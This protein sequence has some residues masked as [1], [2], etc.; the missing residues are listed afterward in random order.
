MSKGEADQEIVEYIKYKD[1]KKQL[2]NIKKIN[3]IDVEI[4]HNFPKFKRIMTIIRSEQ[5]TQNIGAMILEANASINFYSLVAF[6]DNDNIIRLHKF[7]S[8]RLPLF[9]HLFLYRALKVSFRWTLMS[10]LLI[11]PSEL[12]WDEFQWNRPSVSSP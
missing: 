7:Y 9:A 6:F 5:G 8:G 11:V 4:S 1:K 12:R 2:L 10:C 3:N